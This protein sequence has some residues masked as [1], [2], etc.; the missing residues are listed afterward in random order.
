L[1]AYA[2][3]L[4]AMKRNT[5]ALVVEALS[6]AYRYAQDANLRRTQLQRQGKDP[7]GEC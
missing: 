2:D 6:S 5:D 4:A 3:T 1:K 7:A